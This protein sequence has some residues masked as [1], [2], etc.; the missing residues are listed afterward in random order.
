MAILVIA[1]NFQ[2]FILFVRQETD[3]LADGE[4]T[5]TYRYV[6]NPE[7]LH[8]YTGEIVIVNDEQCDLRR[9]AFNYDD[10]HCTIRWVSLT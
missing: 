4:E 5:P 8:G 7:R 9:F 10:K 6:A 2:Q 1:P 3:A